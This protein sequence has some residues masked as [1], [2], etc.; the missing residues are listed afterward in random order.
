[1][2][3]KSSFLDDFKLPEI[4]H[5]AIKSELVKLGRTHTTSKRHSIEGMPLDKRVEYVSEGILKVLGKYKDFVKVIWSKEEL[6]EY[7]KAADDKVELA[8]DTETNNSLDPIT[9]KLMGACL[10]IQNSYP[11]YVPVN[12]CKLGTD[13]LLDGQLT[14]E[15]IK[16]SFRILEEKKIPVIMHNGKFDI[17]VMRNTCNIEMPIY[18]D[19]MIAAQLLNENETAKLKTQFK[20]YIDPTIDAYNIETFFAGIP[21]KWVPVDVFAIY[22]AIDAYD[23]YLLYRAQKEAFSKKTMEKLY[24]LFFEVEMPIVTI[25]SKM[26]DN[27]VCM[28]VEYLNNLDQKYKKGLEEASKEIDKVLEDHAGEVRHYQNIGKL[29]NPI[30]FE[31][32]AQLAIVMYDILK[33]PLPASGKRSTAKE[34]INSLDTPFTKA[35]AKYRQYSI[36]IKLFT[37]PIPGYINKSDGKLHAHFNQMGREENNVVTGRFSSTEPK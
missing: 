2:Y 31:S 36:I 32:S 26:E 22:A 21:Y 8:F 28:D 10:Y 15:E 14:E 35:L 30:N 25:V 37:T 24:K 33:T 27:G 11:A 23:T 3:K 4:T 1:M 34:I 18:W 12:H 5:E 13:E 6:D 17:R 20:K 19:T 7:L 16:D 29:D 9:C